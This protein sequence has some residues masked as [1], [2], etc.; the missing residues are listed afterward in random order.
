MENIKGIIF[1]YGGTID[2]RGDHWSHIIEAAYRES[3]INIASERFREAYIFGERTLAA[4]RIVECS[5]TFLD[6]MRKK[7]SVQLQFLIDNS[8]LPED[9]VEKY[10]SQIANICDREAR[11]A[12]DEARPILE[13]IS[14]NFPMVLVSNFYGNIESVLREYSLRHLFKGIIESAV[15]GVRKPDPAIFRMGVISLGLPPENVLVVGDSLSKDIYPARSLGCQTSWIKGR[16]W[17]PDDDKLHDPC[18]I[19]SLQSLLHL[20]GL[21]D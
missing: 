1:D 7:I 12:V 20:L 9:S 13:K 21:T 5:D 19:S 14:R 15:V 17:S 2:S 6:T 8:T 16:G 3:G 10:S 18:Q 11:K 4:K